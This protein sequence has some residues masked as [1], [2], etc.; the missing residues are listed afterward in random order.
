[1]LPLIQQWLPLAVATLVLLLLFTAI[2]GIR[3]HY[4]KTRSEKN[5]DTPQRLCGC[6]SACDEHLYQI[7]EPTSPAVNIPAED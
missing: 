6:A 3:L 4:L 7:S 2:L 5:Q 1:M